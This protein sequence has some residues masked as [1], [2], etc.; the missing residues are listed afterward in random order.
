MRTGD[1]GVIAPDGSV[2][3]RGRSKC[4]IL[5]A[6][7]QNIYPEEIESLIN[8]MP[9]VEES[10]VVSRKGILVALV[11]MAKDAVQP[12]SELL[13][14][15]NR[16]LPSFSRIARFEVMTEPFVHTPKHSIKRSLYM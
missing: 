9:G 15:L 5:S 3:L 4:M 12:S 14:T 8:N 11:A 13:N 10:L 6:S 1:L 7:G 2:F 16:Q